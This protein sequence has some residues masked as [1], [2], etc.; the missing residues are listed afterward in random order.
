MPSSSSATSPPPSG[1]QPSITAAPPAALMAARAY[2]SAVDDDALVTAAPTSWVYVD[3][4]APS[5]AATEA[6][7]RA[8]FPALARDHDAYAADLT[9]AGLAPTPLAAMASRPGHLA[10]LAE[11]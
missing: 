7:L 6:R 8:A 1:A 9:A 10:L 5:A 11:L 4:P 2:F 3:D